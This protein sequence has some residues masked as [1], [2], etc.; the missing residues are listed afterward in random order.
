MNTR[1]GRLSRPFQT[2]QWT[3]EKRTQSNI[4]NLLEINVLDEFTFWRPSRWLSN[5]NTVLATIVG[6]TKA[7]SDAIPESNSD[8]SHP[9]TLLPEGGLWQWLCE[10]V[11]EHLSS[12][13]VAQVDLSSSSHICSKIVLGRKVCNSNSAVD[14]VLD[15]RDQWLWVGEHVRDSRDAELVHEMRD[16]CES[17]AAYFEGIVFGIGRGLGCLLLFSQF[18]VDR[19]SEG[20]DQSTCR[21][22]VIR[23]VSKGY[24]S[25]GRFRVP[26]QP[27]TEPTHSVST[28]KPLLKSQHFLLQLSIWVL[29]IWQDA[30]HVDCAHLVAPSPPT[31]RCAIRQGFVE[32]RSKPRQFRF[33]SAFISQP[34]NEYQSDR[35][36]QSGR[37]NND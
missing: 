24:K 27:G 3:K 26:F 32:S 17:H 36:S 8:H 22:I 28:Q 21:F 16:L 30:Q 9:S 18:P 34:L 25:P 37:W 31:F 11:C 23:S 2:K 4:V 35:K 13:Y 1:P 6:H 19:S 20:D 10:A 12:R 15:A 29:T 5:S 33:N 14:C 7:I